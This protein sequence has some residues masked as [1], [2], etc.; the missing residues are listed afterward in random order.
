MATTSPASP[1]VHPSSPSSLLVVH[2]PVLITTL[3]VSVIPHQ[4]QL[5]PHGQV[6]LPFVH[7][8]LFYPLDPIKMLLQLLP[9]FLLFLPTHGSSYGAFNSVRRSTTRDHERK[10]SVSNDTPVIAIENNSP[11]ETAVSLSKVEKSLPS[12]TTIKDLSSS[13]LADNLLPSCTYIYLVCSHTRCF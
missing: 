11:V 7:F 9:R 13:S 12:E 5:L 8:A 2:L 1:L 4:H 6:S 3:R 10:A